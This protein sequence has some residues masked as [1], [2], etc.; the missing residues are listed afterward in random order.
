MF[1]RIL[2]ICLFTFLVGCEEKAEPISLTTYSV[3][4]SV[5]LGK[6]FEL[7]DTND[8]YS[9]RIRKVLEDVNKLMIKVNDSNDILDTLNHEIFY[10]V[11]FS[12]ID[13]FT[14]KHPCSMDS[15]L[16]VSI[17]KKLNYNDSVKALKVELDFISY[18]TSPE[19]ANYSEMYLNE[20]DSVES[21]CLSKDG[22]MCNDLYA[23]ITISKKLFSENVLTGFAPNWPKEQFDIHINE[24][25]FAQ[26]FKI[27]DFLS[28]IYEERLK[29]RYEM[30]KI[31]SLIPFEMCYKNGLATPCGLTKEISSHIKNA[32]E[33]ERDTLIAITYQRC[34]M[35]NDFALDGMS[36]K[37]FCNSTDGVHCSE[38]YALVR[39]NDNVVLYLFDLNDFSYT[40]EELSHGDPMWIRY[41]E[42]YKKDGTFVGYEKRHH[43]S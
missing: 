22:K 11:C 34:F 16:L 27:D 29:R 39:R 30:G 8:I 18:S 19:F 41:N 35:M 6:F 24:S 4:D 15:T 21:K 38:L 26:K 23:H 14:V 31:D 28:S 2:I 7:N 43:S 3:M 10:R 20:D 5:S 25:N 42:L 1:F 32:V 37:H 33:K 17:T 13:G 40:V 36:S 9:G 12:D